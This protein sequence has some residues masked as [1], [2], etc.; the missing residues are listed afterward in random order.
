MWVAPKP[1]PISR[2]PM[3]VTVART[4]TTERLPTIIST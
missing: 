3:P 1:M 2:M 4:T